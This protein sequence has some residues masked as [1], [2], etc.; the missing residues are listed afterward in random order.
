M[1]YGIDPSPRGVAS[2]AS[3]ALDATIVLVGCGGTG[4]FLAEATCRLLIGRA[5]SLYLVDMDRVEEHN[6]GRQ[7][8]DPGEIG[9]FKAQVLAERLAR[10]FRCTIGYAVQP[11]D[12]GLHARIFRAQPSRLNL[13]VG[14]VDNADARRALTASSEGRSDVWWLD[15]GNG[16]NS[17]QVLLGNAS[18]PDGLRGAFDEREGVCRALP[19]PALQRPDLLD[20]PPAPPPALDCA[21]AIAREIQ[22]PTINQVVAAIAA[23]FVEKLLAGSCRMMSAYFDLDDVT[24]RCILAEPKTV[25]GIVGLHPKAVTRRS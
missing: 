1:A 15:C 19:S 5:A 23:S 22:G 3:D 18:H 12:A 10:R 21:E 14:C 6:V 25:A 16:R 20:A 17:G 8:F 2:R 13:L 24:L 7:A 4:S 11:Y 9:G